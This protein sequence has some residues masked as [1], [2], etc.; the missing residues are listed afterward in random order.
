MNDTATTTGRS[1]SPQLR[2]MKAIAQRSYGSPDVLQLESVDLPVIGDD[3]VLVRVRAAALNHADSVYL[4]GRPLIAHAL[5]AVRGVGAST[6]VTVVG[7]EREQVS[8][9]IA[10]LELEVIEA[11]QDEQRGT[12]HA[13]QI[14]LDALDGP[15]L[16]EL[17]GTARHDPR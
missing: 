13:V 17:A 4:S 5:L 15:A 16:E 2:T 12:G 6:T 9:A 10:D 1:S 14:A 3:D 7:H 8:A 11:I